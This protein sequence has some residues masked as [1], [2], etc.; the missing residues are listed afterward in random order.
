MKILFLASIALLLSHVV[1]GGDEGKGTDSPRANVQTKLDRRP[2]IESFEVGPDEA[3]VYPND[4]MTRNH[5]IAFPDEHTTF[6]PF[7]APRSVAPTRS[8]GNYLVFGAGKIAR[9]IGGA[10]VLETTDLKH[11]NFA[12]ESGYERQALNPPLPMNRCDPA[13]NTEFDENYAAPGS[14]VQDPTLPPGNLTMVYEA[15]NHCPGGTMQAPFYA[16]VGFAR[17]ADNGKSWPK[18]EKGELGGPNR[19]P[20]LRGHEEPPASAH[21]SMGDSIPTAFVDKNENGEYYLYVTYGYHPG[22]VGSDDG[23][24]RMARARLGVSRENDEKFL[25]DTGQAGEK[26]REQ[27]G[28]LH[29]LKWYKGQFREPGI[30]GLDSGVLPGSG[31]AIR[32]VHPEISY[33]DDLKLYM[34]IFVG[35]TDE[36][37][38]RLGAWY[39]STATS[40][41]LQN[42]TAP[43][44]IRNSQ[45][46]IT[47]PCQGSARGGQFDGWYPSFMSPGHATG[48]TGLTGR[49]FFLNGCNTGKRLFTSRSFTITTEP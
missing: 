2:R 31:S 23:L 14:V 16:T 36:Q 9:G 42:W 11:F 6:L 47:T 37:K 48:H 49:V 3:L 13:L 25:R 41:D 7:S 44:M 40:L 12:T 30:G 34:M 22:K 32:Q 26:G 19:Y 46:P 17:S 27:G 18:P 4:P 24:A 43:Q 28:Q 1:F 33:N 29:F 45:F 20:V 5:L 35:S 8:A 39:Y 38:R 10:V 21:P 15:E